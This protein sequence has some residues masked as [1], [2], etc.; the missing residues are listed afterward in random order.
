MIRGGDHAPT[1]PAPLLLALRHVA[2][3]LITALALLLLFTL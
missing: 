2:A 1:M 3:A